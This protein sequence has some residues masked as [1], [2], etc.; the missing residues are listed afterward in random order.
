MPHPQGIYYANCDAN[1]SIIYK[2]NTY[3]EVNNNTVKLSSSLFR[4]SDNI[5]MGRIFTIKKKTL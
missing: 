4:K 5:L 3:E 2:L 1:D